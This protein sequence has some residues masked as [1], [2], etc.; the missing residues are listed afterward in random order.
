MEIVKLARNKIGKW[1][2][3]HWNGNSHQFAVYCRYPHIKEDEVL[4][5]RKNENKHNTR[6]SI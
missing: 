6:S 5:I 1:S 4:L 3:T 2:E